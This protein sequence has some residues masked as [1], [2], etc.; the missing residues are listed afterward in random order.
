MTMTSNDSDRAIMPSFYSEATKPG[1]G[2]L[3]PNVSRETGPDSEP[4]FT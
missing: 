2:K 3:A 4:R 1:S